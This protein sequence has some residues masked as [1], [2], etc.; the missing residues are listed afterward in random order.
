MIEILLKGLVINS[1]KIDNVVAYLSKFS[2]DVSIQILCL[3]ISTLVICNQLNK[4][5]KAIKLLQN[6]VEKLK[7][8][9]GENSKPEGE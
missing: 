8:Q 5:D 1:T 6:E 9:I 4:H 2:K 3:L 7:K